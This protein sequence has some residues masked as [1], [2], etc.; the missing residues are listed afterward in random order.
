[1]CLSDLFHRYVRKVLVGRKVD[2]DIKQA[3][4]QG[5]K[6][7]KKCHELQGDFAMP[8]YEYGEIEEEST[9]QSF[10]VKNGDEEEDRPST[11]HERTKK[12]NVTTR[13][14]WASP[15]VG[16]VT[17]CVIRVTNDG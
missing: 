9:I 10:K 12:K 7:M 15:E 8:K 16:T 3:Q 13:P 4:Y 5:I 2:I 14:R 6:D 11:G 1:M 17:S